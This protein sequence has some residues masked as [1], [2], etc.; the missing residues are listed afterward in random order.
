WRDVD[1]T[2]SSQVF[3]TSQDALWHIS[4]CPATWPAVGWPNAPVPHITPAS[5]QTNRRRWNPGGKHYSGFSAAAKEFVYFAGK[6]VTSSAARNFA[7]TINN[8]HCPSPG[9]ENAT[10]PG[11]ESFRLRNPLHQSRCG[12]SAR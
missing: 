4:G 7:D 5:L 12:M 8:Q 1:I 3:I 10:R 9:R 6:S 11:P 2:I